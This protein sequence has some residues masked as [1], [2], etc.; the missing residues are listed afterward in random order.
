MLIFIFILNNGL[1]IF[2]QA[3]QH[4]S[5]H[6]NHGL[7]AFPG[8][9][10][11]TIAANPATPSLVSQ[12]SMI[13]FQAEPKDRQKLA[14]PAHCKNGV[15][16]KHNIAKINGHPFLLSKCFK[17]VPQTESTHSQPQHASHQYPQVQHKQRQ[18]NN[19]IVMIYIV[20]FLNKY[21]KFNYFSLNNTSNA[22]F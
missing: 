5:N 3:L 19:F 2:P 11:I 17:A 16:Q 22:I 6:P 10:G 8:F 14:H 13:F 18:L 9:S 12:K 7:I 21:I 1:F 20:N 15:Q 4:L